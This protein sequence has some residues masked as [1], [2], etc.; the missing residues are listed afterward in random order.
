MVSDLLKYLNL[1][2][3]RQ[4]NTICLPLNI[5]TLMDQAGMDIRLQ[6]QRSI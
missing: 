4:L 3:P 2:N 6:G 5:M 1:H